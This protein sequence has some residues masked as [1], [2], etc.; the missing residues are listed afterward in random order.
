MVPNSAL[1]QSLNMVF[2][3]SL[4][5]INLETDEYVTLET[6]KKDECELTKCLE[7]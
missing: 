7:Y 4:K 5:L 3:A 1:G 6:G 2:S